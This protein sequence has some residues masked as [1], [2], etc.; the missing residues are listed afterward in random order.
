MATMELIDRETKQKE[1]LVRRPENQSKVYQLSPKV[2]QS[3][4][5]ALQEVRDG[6]CIPGETVFRE[7]DEWLGSD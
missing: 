2:R 6:Q 1:R 4:D 3:I 7:I 5:I